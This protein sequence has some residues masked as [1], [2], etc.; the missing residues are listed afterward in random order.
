MAA[1][2]SWATHFSAGPLYPSCNFADLLCKS[3]RGDVLANAEDTS[4]VGWQD[5][6]MKS[7]E[8]RYNLFI[9]ELDPTKAFEIEAC[10]SMTSYLI[11]WMSST[12]FQTLVDSIF[13]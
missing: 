4:N 3:V 2:D 8:D 7:Y 13:T 12:N 10:Y 11:M 1:G 6:A 5:R 9:T